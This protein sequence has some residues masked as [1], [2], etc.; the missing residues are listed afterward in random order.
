MKLGY[1]GMPFCGNGKMTWLVTTWNHHMGQGDAEDGVVRRYCVWNASLFS[2]TWQFFWVF[3][4][5]WIMF[6]S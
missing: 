5:C 4:W 6:S 2:C 3:K 1:E